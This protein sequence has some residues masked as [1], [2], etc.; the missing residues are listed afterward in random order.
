MTVVLIGERPGLATGESMSCYMI[1]KGKVGNKES[2][3]TVISNIHKSG[4][5]AVEAGAH[6]AD[7]I[8]KIH[9]MKKSGVDLK[10]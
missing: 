3:R 8:K 4:T 9:D 6:I 5:P 10:L 2:L 1:Y 7:V